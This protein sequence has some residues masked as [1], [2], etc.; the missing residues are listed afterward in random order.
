M[1]LFP[2]RIRWTDP[3][4]LGTADAVGV[5]RCDDGCEYA[6]K[7]SSKH[8]RTPHNEWFCSH[9]ASTIGIAGPP[10]AIVERADGV[11]VFGS[12]WEGGVS[13]EPWHAMIS[14]GTIV[15]DDVKGTLAKVFAYDNFVY[16]DD[17]HVGN[18]VMRSQKNGYALLTLDYSRSWLY[19][20]FPPAALP[21]AP[22]KN[23]ISASRWITATLGQYITEDSTRE[24]LDRIEAVTEKDVLGIINQ[25]PQSWL[26]EAERDQIASWWM[27]SARKERLYNLRKGIKDGTY[28]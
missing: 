22:G 14:N 5:C 25:H 3:A 2:L 11:L 9:L 8:A 24:T 13:K 28:L 20:G 17:R 6:L 4:G 21:F 18:F 1:P 27:S 7:D 12:R 19:H 10:C 26:T 15:F 23:T 16:N